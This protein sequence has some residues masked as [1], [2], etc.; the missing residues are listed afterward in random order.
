MLLLVVED[1]HAIAKPLCR[2][3]RREGFD[4]EWVTTGSAALAAA[5]PD[6]VLLDLG[7]PDTDGEA[8]CRELRRRSTVPIIVVTARSDEL[9][10]V[11]L[12]ELG[13]DDYV[14]KPFGSRELVARVVRRQI[15]TTSSARGLPPVSW[16]PE[17]GA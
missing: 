15:G 1:D 7:L 10:R 2:G 8:V 9:D 12:L 4:V 3:L 5:V 6:L 14:V 13:A 17:K 16:T 11:A